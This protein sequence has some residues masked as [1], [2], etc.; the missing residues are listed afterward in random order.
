MKTCPLRRG[1]IAPRK[2]IF[3]GPVAT[4]AVRLAF[5]LRGIFRKYGSPFPVHP[6]NLLSLVLLHGTQRVDGGSPERCGHVLTLELAN[7]ILF[8]KMVFAD[9]R[10]SWIQSGALNPTAGVLPREI[11]DRHGG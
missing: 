5:A 10:P 1:L 7:G 3:R 9:R 2:P 4:L 6:A 11:W 8:G